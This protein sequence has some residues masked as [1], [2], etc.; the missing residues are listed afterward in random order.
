M[1]V[2]DVGTRVRLRPSRRADIVDLALAGKLAEVDGVEH[3]ADGRVY[4]AVSLLG[5]TAVD[6]GPMSQLGHRFFFDPE[7]LEPLPGGSARRV[8]VA[9]AGDGFKPAE[10]GVGAVVE[11]LRGRDLPPGVRVA[12]FGLR[13]HDLLR[14][15]EDYDAAVLLSAELGPGE[16]GPPP[17]WLEPGCAQITAVGCG[18]EIED[19]VLG[20]VMSVVDDLVENAGSREGVGDEG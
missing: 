17:A 12:D 10:R 1:T 16:L 14:A 4:V 7:E 6:L 13:R 11:A 15:L 8:L 20:V 19:R 3:G 9:G 5:D 18:A 2:P